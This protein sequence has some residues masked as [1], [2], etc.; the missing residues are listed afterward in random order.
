[1]GNDIVADDFG[2]G[3]RFLFH[4]KGLALFHEGKLCVYYT[5]ESNPSDGWADPEVHNDPPER[6]E[7]ALKFGTNIVVYALTR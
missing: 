1:M 4:I 2:V 5:Y 7:L 6:R 3:R